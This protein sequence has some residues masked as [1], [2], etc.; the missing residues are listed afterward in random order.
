MEIN[1]RA[2]IFYKS[3]I[4]N[5]QRRQTD[6][7]PKSDAFFGCRRPKTPEHG[8]GIY[9]R[10]IHPIGEHPSHQ[11]NPYKTK[12]IAN[13]SHFFSNVN[14]YSLMKTMTHQA[15]ATNKIHP[16]DHHTSHSYSIQ[17]SLLQN[18]RLGTSFEHLVCPTSSHVLPLD[19]M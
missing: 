17:T 3:N 9:K 18:N 13:R 7:Q 14:T 2:T 16:R 15:F 11:R 5:H 19:N 8:N 1:C 4:P 12:Y 10:N 6:N